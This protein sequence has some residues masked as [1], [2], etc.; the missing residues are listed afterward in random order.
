MD[1]RVT[2]ILLVYIAYA[3]GLCINHI[4]GYLGISHTL[5]TLYVQHMYLQ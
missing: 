5:G 2:N 4:P 1:D 3:P